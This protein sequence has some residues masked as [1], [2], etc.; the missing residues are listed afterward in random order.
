MKG[1]SAARCVNFLFSSMNTSGE[2]SMHMIML[3]N[4]VGVRRGI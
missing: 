3:T 4:S 2:R 1:V